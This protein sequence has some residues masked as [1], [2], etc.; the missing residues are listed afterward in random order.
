MPR[1]FSV[2]LWPPALGRSSLPLSEVILRNGFL[3]SLM[4]I[5][6][7]IMQNRQAIL[8]LLPG[9]HGGFHGRGG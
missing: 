5:N 3:T 6:D 9:K 7:Q 8:S 2:G 4:W 1:S